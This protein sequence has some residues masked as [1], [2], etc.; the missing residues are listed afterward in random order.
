MCAYLIWHLYWMFDEHLNSYLLFS[1][2]LH[3]DRG[4]M[5]HDNMCF[6]TPS[7]DLLRCAGEQHLPLK[8]THRCYGSVP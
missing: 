1:S 7:N 2:P 6:M 5:M 4:R 3:V 8:S